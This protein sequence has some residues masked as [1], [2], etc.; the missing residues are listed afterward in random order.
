M[1]EFHR[2]NLSKYFGEDENKI[3]EI[4]NSNI[5]NTTEATL[6]DDE[7]SNNSTEQSTDYNNL[8]YE[9]YYDLRILYDSWDEF[10]QLRENFREKLPEILKNTDCMRNI[11]LSNE[12]GEIRSKSPIEDDFKNSL[13]KLVK[14]KNEPWVIETSRIIINAIRGIDATMNLMKLSLSSED[15][16]ELYIELAYGIIINI[17]LE[18]RENMGECELNR[19]CYFK[20]TKCNDETTYLFNEKEHQ[21]ICATCWNN[22]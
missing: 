18:T 14:Y 16:D 21:D 15:L 10:E 20:C 12:N 6:D 1:S 7:S 9:S 8:E 22:N 3:K 4:C 19:L 5:K 11:F 13:R 2:K 17:V